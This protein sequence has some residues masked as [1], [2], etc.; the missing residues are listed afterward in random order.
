MTLESKLQDVRC[1]LGSGRFVWRLVSPIKSCLMGSGGVFSGSVVFEDRLH[2]YHGNGQEE[3]K[4]VTQVTSCLIS[5]FM[6]P[7]CDI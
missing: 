2:L 5:T 1:F 3:L 7:I 6:L 4:E